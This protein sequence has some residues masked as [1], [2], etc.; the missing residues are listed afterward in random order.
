MLQVATATLSFL[1]SAAPAAGV[2]YLREAQALYNSQDY[3]ACL[4]RIDQARKAPVAGDEAQVE[5]VGALCSSQLGKF[6]DAESFFRLALRID[7]SLVLP[8]DVSPK[9]RATF[10]KARAAI[11]K[12]APQPPQELVNDEPRKPPADPKNPPAEPR[13]DLHVTPPGSASSSLSAPAWVAIGAGSSTAVAGAVGIIFGVLASSAAASAAS[14]PTDIAFG[15]RVAEARAQQT[16]ANVAWGVAAALA[17]A[18]GIAT[19]VTLW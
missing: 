8:G 17:V 9:I 3:E 5:F 7:K 6:A 15:Q 2:A 11:E 16:T 1:L 4:A 14:A 10:E 12:E 19:G 18:T 13:P